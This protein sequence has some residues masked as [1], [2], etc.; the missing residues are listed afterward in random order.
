VV[1]IL[2]NERPLLVAFGLVEKCGDFEQVAMAVANVCLLFVR[3]DKAV[4]EPIDFVKIAVGP[5]LVVPQERF[6]D[7]FD[8][9]LVA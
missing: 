7:R 4:A 5:H 8:L 9:Q 6:V 1:E 2:L 3:A